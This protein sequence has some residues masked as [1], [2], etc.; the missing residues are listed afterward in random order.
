MPTL[1]GNRIEQI[2]VAGQM[3]NLGPDVSNLISA[4]DV[5]TNYV[6]KADYDTKVE[7]IDA[8]IL[9][10]AKIAD[11]SN[12]FV[13]K[14]DWDAIF[15]NTADSDQVINK[16]KEVVDFLDGMSE[17]TSLGE[18]LMDKA[19]KNDI[20]TFMDEDDVSAYLTQ[21]GIG[22]VDLTDYYTKTEIDTSI[23]A[24]YQVKGNYLTQHQS[25]ADYYTKTQCDNKFAQIQLAASTDAMDDDSV[26]YLVLS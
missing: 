10:R 5:S 23:A 12:N 6:K 13:K 22:Q 8:S 17:D 16:W 4:A 14:E 3:V 7:N 21:H 18:L 25:L 1:N 20:S 9:E 11:V 15:S 24:N 2:K 26:I 19:S